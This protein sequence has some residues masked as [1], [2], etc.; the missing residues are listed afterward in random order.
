LVATTLIATLATTPYTLA[1]F[2][3]FTLQTIVGNVLAIPLTSI[4]IM[5]V[6]TFSVLSLLFGGSDVAFH[7]LSFGLGQLVG[8]AERVASW[9]GAA[10]MVAKPSPA[11][12]AL[13]T[14]GGLWICLWKNPWRWGGLVLC[15]LGC[16]TLF[17][18]NPTTIYV[19]GD[20]SVMAY[21]SKE[22]LYVSSLKRGSFFRDQWM[23]ESGV[24]QKK[25]WPGDRI[26]I[27]PVLLVRF[28][29]SPLKF[30]KEMCQKEA[31]VTTGYA[32]RDCKRWK[33]LPDILIDRYT[34]KRKGTCQL[35]V[36]PHGVDVKF[37]RPFLGKRPWSGE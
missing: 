9:P 26:K 2:N 23:K 1:I 21:R 11:F 17:F 5:P 34:L 7:L 12:V 13:V 36:T 33:S 18:R 4:F 37:V 16:M 20:G 35:W 27:G 22:T 28:Q 3:R 30:S 19:A 15:G 24:S 32:W 6:A 8:I 31:L 10:I 14:L 25:E 29:N